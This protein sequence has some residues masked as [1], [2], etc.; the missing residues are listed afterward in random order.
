MSITVKVYRIEHPQKYVHRDVF[1]AEYPFKSEVGANKY[2][3]S[4]M[5]D[6]AKK[7]KNDL[8]AELYSNGK[9]KTEYYCT[10]KLKWYLVRVT[11]I[12]KYT[13]MVWVD[14]KWQDHIGEPT[15]KADLIRLKDDRVL[16]IQEGF[17]TEKQARMWAI[18]KLVTGSY[19]NIREISLSPFPDGSGLTDMSSHLYSIAEVNGKLNV[20]K[21]YYGYVT[22]SMDGK[23]HIEYRKI[24][25]LT[26][27]GQIIKNSK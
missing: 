2:I 17:S 8:K 18:K 11:K 27:S 20:Y 25:T 21:G 16:D 23:K 9:L 10:A 5:D 7:S 12:P 14:G 19:A 6:S 24:G 22:K 4:L 1:V 26:A 13:V 15:Y 3:H